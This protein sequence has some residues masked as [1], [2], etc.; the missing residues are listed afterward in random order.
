L[1][2][3]GKNFPVTI[4]M[5]IEKSIQITALCHQHSH[6]EL[7][8]ASLLITAYRG[9]IYWCLIFAIKMLKIIFKNICNVFETRKLPMR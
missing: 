8:L 7:K 1:N 3:V 4:R 2:F 9:T 5:H 6:V